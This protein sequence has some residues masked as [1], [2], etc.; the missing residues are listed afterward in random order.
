MLGQ[1]IARNVQLFQKVPKA[2]RFDQV[3]ANRQSNV[4]KKISKLNEHS[5]SE[6]R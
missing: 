1:R 6:N 5:F 3:I 4:Q 2:K